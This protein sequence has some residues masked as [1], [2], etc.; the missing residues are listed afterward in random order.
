V[1]LVR[2]AVLSD[3]HANIEAFQSVVSDFK[4]RID[5]VLNLGDIV[6]YNASPNECVQLARDIGMHSILGNHDQAACNPALAEHFN[7]FARNAILWTRNNLSDENIQFLGGLE[8]NYRLSCN[9]ACHG[10]PDDVSSYIALPFQARATLKKMRKGFWGDIDVCLFG[11]THKRKVWRMD[12]RGKVSPIE[13]PTDGI[14][15]LNGEELYLLNPG[16]V[17]QP[18]NG[19]PRASYFLFDT[20]ERAVNF[21][22]VEYN[23][24]S[25]IKKIMDANLPEFFAQRLLDGT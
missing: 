15:K 24:A 25:T 17:G 8:K 21:R 16:S 20:E 7:I 4:N 3:I 11:H 2:I 14:I 6:G 12:V 1:T 10:S 19:D 5:R 23:M 13:I 9:L 22:L 18:R